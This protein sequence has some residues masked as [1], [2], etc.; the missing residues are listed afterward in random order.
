MFILKR[1]HNL[2]VGMPYLC[3]FG[4]LQASWTKDINEAI[5]YSTSKAALR[6]LTQHCVDTRAA[7]MHTSLIRIQNISNRPKYEEVETL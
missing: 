4:S 3:A 6:D 7:F 2:A 5:K 1:D